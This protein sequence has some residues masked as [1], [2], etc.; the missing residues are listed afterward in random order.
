MNRRA[1]SCAIAFVTA[2]CLFPPHEAV[3]QVI[4]TPNDH[5]PNF[6]ASPTIRSAH[7]GMWSSPTT[8]NPARVPLP[9]DIVSVEHTVTYDSIS[10]DVEV[11][12]IQAGGILQFSNS[13]N[14]RL[15][16]GTLVVLVN[17]TL[18]VGT[19]SNPIPES[20]I[21]E[22]SIK[23][24]PLNPST[25]PDQY[26]TGL[27]CIDGT[28]MMHGAIKSPTFVRM[29]SGAACWSHHA[30]PRTGGDRL[31]R[32]RSNFSAGHTPGACRPLVQSELLASDRRANHSE[33]QRRRENNHTRF[34]AQLRSSRRERCRRNAD[35]RCRHSTAA[36]RRKP[37]PQ[38]HR[39]F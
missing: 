10:G 19:P 33:H 24:R 37:D 13:Q 17:G 18:E 12:G 38:C 7:P 32:R 4:H 20:V 34:P 25:D 14:T 29:A 3:A 15:R 2:T 28:V 26:G 11:I 1:V 9:S 16:V 21:A 35:R 27:L 23:D 31:A 30:R 22:I 6:A 36:A 39:P 8:W 5:V